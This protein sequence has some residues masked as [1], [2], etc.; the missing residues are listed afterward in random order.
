MYYT[1]EG[2]CDK[3]TFELDVVTSDKVPIIT[4]SEKTII[5]FISAVG[6]ERIRFK[7]T[8]T[9]KDA[10]IVEEGVFATEINGFKE[11]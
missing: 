4:S 5:D 9:V 7:V 11:Q 1:F 10:E 6:E 3:L 2:K 8:V